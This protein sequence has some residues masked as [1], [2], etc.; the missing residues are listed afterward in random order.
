VRNGFFLP[1]SSNLPRLRV[2]DPTP[3]KLSTI[4]YKGATGVLRSV[5][6][7]MTHPVGFFELLLL[8][9]WSMCNIPEIIG[10]IEAHFSPQNY[11]ESASKRF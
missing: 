9:K 11:L 6:L 5:T 1:Y 10:L 3:L 8:Q 4:L 7:L 2:S